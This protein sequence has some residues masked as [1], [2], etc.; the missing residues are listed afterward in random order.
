VLHVA[1]L[2]FGRPFNPPVIAAVEQHLAVIRYDV[3]VVAGDLAQR[4][5]SGEFQRAAVFLETARQVSEVVVV[6]GN[7]DVAWWVSPLHLRGMTPMFARYRRYVADELEPV[8]ATRGALFA[9]LNTSHGVALYSLT[10]RLRDISIVGATRPEQFVRL[11][12]TF[13]AATP[14]QARVV[15]MH[16]NPTWGELSRRFGVVD[17]PRVL[18]RLSEAGTDLIL[19]GHDHHEAVAQ[20]EHAGRSMV[21][22]TAGTLSTR[23]RHGRPCSFHAI[24]IGAREI[25]VTTHFWTANGGSFSPGERQCFAR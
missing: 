6:P 17:T 14:G 7:H 24:E 19:C 5:L 20:V 3:V 10:T 1:D 23:S 9:G 11:G 16:H 18:D 25:A 4:S 12:E 22:C 2:H 21:I 13:A 8:L 15:V